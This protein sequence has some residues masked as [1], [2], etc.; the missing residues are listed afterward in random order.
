MVC[1]QGKPGY[2][3]EEALVIAARKDGKAWVRGGNYTDRRTSVPNSGCVKR[4]GPVHCSRC[5]L[6]APRLLVYVYNW[7]QRSR[8]DGTF[9]IITMRKER[10]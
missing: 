2:V 9:T 8:F 5:E 7:L 4:S 10:E 3:A 6:I 1:C